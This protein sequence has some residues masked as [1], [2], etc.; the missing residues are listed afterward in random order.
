[1]SY[2]ALIP[3]DAIDDK[4]HL[5]LAWSRSPIEPFGY[6]DIPSFRSTIKGHDL[7]GPNKDFPVALMEDNIILSALYTYFALINQSEYGFNPHIT[8]REGFPLREIGSKVV[9]SRIELRD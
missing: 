4:E 8:K 2:I 1:M 6:Q 3:E 5:T 7:F 9:F